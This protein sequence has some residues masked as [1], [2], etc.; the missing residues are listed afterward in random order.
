M[1]D[2]ALGWFRDGT[3]RRA[4]RSRRLDSAGFEGRKAPE[5]VEASIFPASLVIAMII[6]LLAGDYFASAHGPP[7]V[8]IPA[9]G[10]YFGSWVAPRYGEARTDAISR[11]EAQIGRRFAIDHQYYRW[12]SNFPG[13]YE[14]WTASQGRIPL[15]NWKAM[16][17]N[18]QPVAWAS[19]A[20]GAQDATIIARAQAIKAFG[21]PMYLTFHH[22]PEDDLGTWAA[23]LTTPR[24][25][26]TSWTCSD[27]PGSIT[28]RSSGR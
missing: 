16:R 14:T 4:R 2:R 19:I 22:E 8:L 7:A 12:D 9:S 20:S 26:A 25:T 23:P 6:A 11:V 1:V 3:Y 21:S 5:A 15:L 10:A 28:S 13:P 17:S 18:G 24:P 27:P